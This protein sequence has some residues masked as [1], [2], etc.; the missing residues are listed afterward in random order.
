MCECVTDMIYYT[1]LGLFFPVLLFFS[2]SAL[3]TQTLFPLPSVECPHEYRHW[4][5]T[6]A[7]CFRH[8]S[9]FCFFFF[10]SPPSAADAPCLAC[11]R[12]TAEKAKVALM[13]SEGAFCLS[14][15]PSH[16]VHPPVS[17]VAWLFFF[18]L[19]SCPRMP[20]DGDMQILSLENR[21]RARQLSIDCGSVWT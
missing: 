7:N 17:A 14:A 8:Q 19:E 16:A 4:T 13:K 6:P 10:F 20:L 3:P 21:Q 1:S 11:S 5:Q 18:F 15:L 2:V 9:F 12:A